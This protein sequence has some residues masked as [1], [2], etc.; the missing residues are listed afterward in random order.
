MS[1]RATSRARTG[2]APSEDR[3]SAESTSQRIVAAARRLFEERGYHATTLDA[4]A[5]ELRIRAPSLLYHFQSKEDLLDAVLGQFYTEGRERVLEALASPGSAGNR[6]ERVVEVLR[7][8]WQRNGGLLRIAI[9]E[10]MKPDGV[11]RDHVF[12]VALPTLELVEQVLHDSVSP[13]IPANAPVQAATM[14]V[15]ASHILRLAMG[16]TGE[17]LWGP[18]DDLSDLQAILFQGLQEW[19]GKGAARRGRTDSR[20][21]GENAN[22]RARGGRR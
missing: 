14:T 11:G 7:D 1:R 13:P 21:G 22:R 6:L 17:A 2:P 10:L 8:L 19:P 12:E 18:E 20:R 4:I 9:T 15:L 16:N 5:R 3:R